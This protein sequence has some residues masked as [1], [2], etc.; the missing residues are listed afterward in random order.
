MNI[1]FL[2]SSRTQEKQYKE[3]CRLSRINGSVLNIKRPGLGSFVKAV[4]WFL[5]NKERYREWVCFQEKKNKLR[6]METTRLSHIGYM[7]GIILSLAAVIK[8]VKR[9]KLGFLYLRNGLSYKQQAIISWA[10]ESGLKIIYT[11]NG[12]LPAT[13]VLDTKG[14]NFRSSVPAAKEFY[15]GLEAT[16]TD[17][18]YTSL[19][20]RKAKVR[21]AS[22]TIP[23]DYYF[24]PFQVPTDSQVLIYSPWIDSMEKFYSL[25]EKAASFLPENCYFVIKEH[26]SS[27]IRYHDLHFRNS[28]IIFANGNDTQ[29]LIEKS[30]CVITLNSSVGV[31]ALM[32]GNKVITL[33]QAFYNIEGMVN[34]ARSEREF[35]GLVA[36]PEGLVRDE[37]LV[38]KFLWWLEN[39][40]LLPGKL[41]EFEKDATCLNAFV[42]RLEKIALEK[43]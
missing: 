1:L 16:Y 13:F 11:E 18:A 23:E 31:E 39:E 38:K 12:Q 17:S 4:S 36:N 40:Y 25:L 9:H 42:E 21:S 29:E 2:A 22:V 19:V 43:V 5:V 20:P 27:E 26:P 7:V 14:V 10:E 41:R 3:I 24:V 32:L 28:K 6:N 34:H 8:L 35:E 33:G 37:E 30:K 15:F